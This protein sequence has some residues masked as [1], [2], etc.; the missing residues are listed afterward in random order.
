MKPLAN[1]SLVSNVRNRA[2]AGMATKV[3]G[4]GWRFASSSINLN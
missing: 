2:S 3:E 4:T 1:R